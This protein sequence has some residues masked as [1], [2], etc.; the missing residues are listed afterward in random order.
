MS[1]LLEQAIIDAAALKDAAIKNAES[2]LLDKYSNDIRE[3]VENLLEQEEEEKND[4]APTGA[5]DIPLA[6]APE[7]SEG[8]GE[9]SDD[10]IILDMDELQKMADTLA[11]EDESLMGEPASHEAASET[12]LTPPSEVSDEI[13]P[14]DV[15]VTLEEEID[16]VD[17]EAII[18][19]LIVDI[20]PQKEGWVG[21]PDDIMDFK[22]ELEMARMASTKAQEENEALVAANKKLTKENKDLKTKFSTLIDSVNTLKE[23]MEKVNLS[24]ARLVYTNKT[25]ANRSLNERQKNKIVDALSE[26]RSVEEAKVIFETLENAVGSVVGKA[27]PQ[28]LR[29]TIERPSAN[30]PRRADRAVERPAMDRMQILAGIKSHK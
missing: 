22:Q 15:G 13:A 7:G 11:A 8:E 16:T 28:S 24:N 27:Q 1:S 21:T 14:V 17:L 3:A 12:S 30:L 9:S 23:S 2:A 26:A 6:A 25:L 20:E 5:E 19:E 10:V 29:E 18:E 4:D